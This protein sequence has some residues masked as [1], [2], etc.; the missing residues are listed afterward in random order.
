MRT[1]TSLFGGIAV[2]LIAGTASASVQ[3]QS[4]F[5]TFNNGDLVGQ[6]G[7]SQLGASSTNPLQVGNGRVIVPGLGTGNGDGQDAI[8]SFGPVS[9][10]D[11]TSIYAALTLNV[12]TVL[13][14]NTSTSG[15]S[16][17]L[18]LQSNGFA[19]FRVST[20]QGT[21]PGTFQIGIRPTGQSGNTFVFGGDLPLNTDLSLVL[22]W[23]FV[24]GAQ[25]DVTAAYVNPTSL[26]EGDNSA[27]AVNTQANASGDA[28]SFDG[29]LIS[30]FTSAT[31][32]TQTGAT[33]GKVIVT[34]DFGEAV[35]YIPTPGSAVLLGLGGLVASRRRRG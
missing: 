12:N 27:Y 31:S 28:T 25:N 4:D 34:D 18:A 29:L 26:D 10:V 33:I 5:S 7:W 16:Y 30:Q 35:S 1:C 21:T 20:R 24:A 13:A 8:R 17:L 14:P 19:N 2:A 22:A 9:A 15:S 11:N 32:T 23:N 3:F 6:G